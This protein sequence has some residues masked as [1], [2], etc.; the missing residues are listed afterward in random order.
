MKPNQICQSPQGSNAIIMTSECPFQMSSFLLKSFDISYL[1]PD[2][3][4]FF[5]M[6]V[7]DV[8][9]DKL[10]ALEFLA[11]DG[12]Q[13]LVLGEFLGVQGHKLLHLCDQLLR[14]NSLIAEY[15]LNHTY[16]EFACIKPISTIE[17]CLYFCPLYYHTCIIAM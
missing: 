1:S 2:F 11:A 17:W 8:L 9:P 12:T 5:P 10:W 4:H 13:P 15:A 7:K 3:I 6:L 14:P 16:S